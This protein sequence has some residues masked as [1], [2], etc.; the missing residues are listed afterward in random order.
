[1]QKHV[2]ISCSLWI[3]FIASEASLPVEDIDAVSGLAYSSC[4]IIIIPMLNW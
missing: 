4:R 2:S 1:M 3:I